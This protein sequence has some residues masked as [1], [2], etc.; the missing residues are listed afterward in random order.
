M[1]SFWMS[2]LEALAAW[3]PV[4]GPKHWWL[5]QLISSQ[6]DTT[7][8][9]LYACVESS[10]KNYLSEEHRKEMKIAHQTAAHFTREKWREKIQHLG[11]TS[12][13]FL[14]SDYIAR[15]W[16][17]ESMLYNT[18]HVLENHGSQVYMYGWKLQKAKKTPLLRKIWLM[19]TAYNRRQYLSIA[20][21][22]KQHK[23]TVIWLHSVN[24]YLWWLPIS[25]LKKNPSVQVRC[26]IH[27]MGMFHPFGAQVTLLDDIPAS[28]IWG[29]MSI[30]NNP[31]KKLLIAL[32]YLN[33]LFVKKQLIKKVDIWFVP[34]PFLVDLLHQKRGIPLRKIIVLPHFI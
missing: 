16:G 23:P 25:A 2:A 4:I 22:Q 5:Q 12:T 9:W 33:V 10:I 3:V 24:R 32:K 31:I 34:S 26:S 15:V 29:F 30:S 27:D 20:L 6:F 8:I 17:I 7:T 1:E 21:G 18:K 19:S 28:S 14:I 13:V 11:D